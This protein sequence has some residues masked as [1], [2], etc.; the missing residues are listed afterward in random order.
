M[1]TWLVPWQRSRRLGLVASHLGGPDH[2]LADHPQRP[3]DGLRLGAA[4]RRLLLHSKATSA[5]SARHDADR[6]GAGCGRLVLCRGAARVGIRRAALVPAGLHRRRLRGRG[7]AF[8]GRGRAAV[9]G[10]GASCGS[11]FIGL[12]LVVVL[13]RAPDGSR[14]HQR[15][16]SRGPLDES[17]LRYDLQCTCPLCRKL[18]Q[19]G[20][21][22]HCFCLVE[23]IVLFFG[24]VCSSCLGSVVA[25]QASG[26]IHLDVLALLRGANSCQH[27]RSVCFP[28]WRFLTLVL[29]LFCGLVGEQHCRGD[30]ASP[31]PR[32]RGGRGAAVGGAGVG[33]GAALL[34]GHREGDGLVFALE[35]LVH[36]DRDFGQLHTPSGV[37]SDALVNA[38]PR[39]GREGGLWCGRLYSAGA[40]A[41]LP[42]GPA[43]LRVLHLACG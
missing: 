30:K 38:R 17:F 33:V 3:S 31:T 13:A 8:S 22:S 43:V 12:L 34:V 27:P 5:R 20:R 28:C 15:K 18:V 16:F 2:A 35:C 36:P 7:A 10:P 25:Q 29:V 9:G 37:E 21:R 42:R 39:V 23:L 40:V 32:R 14:Q 6:S 41:A 1:R 11:A 24:L 4:L 26:W 19:P